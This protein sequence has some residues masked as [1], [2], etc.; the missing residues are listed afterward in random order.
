MV[1]KHPHVVIVGAGIVGSSLAYHLAR[2]NARVTVIDKAAKSAHDATG[3]SF[4]WIVSAHDA[5]ENSFNFHRQ[6]IADWHRVEAEFN[7]QL[8]V[9]WS[10][11][12]RWHDD[13]LKTQHNVH[14]LNNSDDTVRLVDKKEIR[15]LEPNL[16]NVP[17]QAIFV[18]NEGA[19]DPG[20]TTELFLKAAREAGAVI[21]LGNQVLS[22]MTKGSRI[23]GVM[24]SNGNLSTDIVVLASGVDT[25]TLCQPLGI[26]LPIKISPA[27]LMRLHNNGRF[28]NRIVSNPYME[29]RSASDTLILAAEDYI[30]ESMESNPQAIAQRTLENI[31]K[32]WEGTDQ[33]KLA[34]VMVG[35]R[36][37]P[38]DGQPI[39]GRTRGIEGLYISVMHTGV[40]LA[41]IV[42]RLATS[43]ICSDRDDVSL[44]IYRPER[45]DIIATQ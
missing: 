14:D 13:M 16:K 37:I 36:P 8:K 30:D 20:L 17:D 43:E 45:F 18:K 28:V 27:I 26:T 40:T 32:H 19:F 4:G 2:R 38:Q 42:G 25:N 11:S 29:L 21:Q 23:I 5:P 12:L 33:I 15:R 31:K 22:F 3:K 44:S 41:A 35:R 9:N 6:A 39:I 7:G 10:G 1:S 34:N 24:T